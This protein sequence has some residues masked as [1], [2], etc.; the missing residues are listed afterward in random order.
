M[1]QTLKTWLLTE[2]SKGRKIN[3]YLGSFLSVLDLPSSITGKYCQFHCLK[4]V[5]IENKC[6]NSDVFPFDKPFNL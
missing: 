4:I 5:F 1:I 3:T 2:R 6:F